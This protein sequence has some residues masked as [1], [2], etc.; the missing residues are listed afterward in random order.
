MI[1][2]WMLPILPVFPMRQIIC[3]AVCYV[4]VVGLFAF[5]HAVFC[6]CIWFTKI[7]NLFKNGYILSFFYWVIQ[8]EFTVF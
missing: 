4:C 8:K 1:V 2:N 7:Q 6:Y 3:Y 5:L